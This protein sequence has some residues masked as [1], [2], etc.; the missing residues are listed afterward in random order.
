MLW[1]P[2]ATSCVQPPPPSAA[3]SRPPSSRSSEAGMTFGHAGLSSFVSCAGGGCPFSL[4]KDPLIVYCSQPQYQ[5][6][7]NFF[8]ARLRQSFPSAGSRGIGFVPPRSIIG[9]PTLLRVIRFSPQPTLRHIDA[10]GHARSP[11]GPDRC[12]CQVRY[13]GDGRFR[14]APSWRAKTARDRNAP[15]INTL[16]ME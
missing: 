6:S 8:P 7:A 4:S 9:D 16:V 3:C 10:P 15:N 13:P 14:S 2:C 11:A 5:G 1:P 12:P